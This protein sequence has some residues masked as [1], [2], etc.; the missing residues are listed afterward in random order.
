MGGWGNA[1]VFIIYLFERKVVIHLFPWAA[2]WWRWLTCGERC[3]ESRR[4]AGRQSVSAPTVR[5]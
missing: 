2:G 5:I 1:D 4:V 3:V